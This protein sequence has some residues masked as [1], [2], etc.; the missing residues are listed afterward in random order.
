MK[1]ENEKR[2]ILEKLDKITK[3]SEEISILLEKCNE[4]SDQ[5]H[6]P[7][8]DISETKSICARIRR[9]LEEKIG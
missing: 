5:Y 7:C 3:L 8:L 2:K 4:Y 1:K 9:R 6:K